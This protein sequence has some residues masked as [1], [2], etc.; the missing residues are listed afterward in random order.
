MR[1]RTI[2]EIYNYTNIEEVVMERIEWICESGISAIVNIM[3][4][5][6][7]TA[8]NKIVLR[9][10]NGEVSKDIDINFIILKA[11]IYVD[12]YDDAMLYKLRW[13]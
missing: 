4:F 1:H 7:N 5:T 6:S 10:V 2:F 3:G 8:N 11:V 9:I 13:G 12:D